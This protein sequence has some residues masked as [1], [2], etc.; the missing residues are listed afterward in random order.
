[1]ILG[2]NFTEL[3]KNKNMNALGKP[4]IRKIKG[5]LGSKYIVYRCIFAG[6]NGEGEVF[7]LLLRS[8]IDPTRDYHRWKGFEMNSRLLGKLYWEAYGVEKP[9]EIGI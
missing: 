6:L 8:N 3:E 9:A 1:M 2:K 7:S 4:I 5:D